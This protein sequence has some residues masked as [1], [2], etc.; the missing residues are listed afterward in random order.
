MRRTVIVF[1]AIFM[2]LGG[3]RR[4]RERDAAFP[5]APVILISID[6]LRSDHLPIYGYAGVAT[7]AID[8]FRQ[9]AILARAAWSHSP[10]TLPSHLSML[11]GVAPAEHGVR[12]NIGYRFRAAAHAYLP[13]LLRDRG[14]AT[15]A[16][17]SSYVLRS[18]SGIDACFDEYE[19]SI[20]PRP[21]A[22]FA[23]YQRPGSE[24]ARTA[25]AWITAQ[26]DRPFFHFFHIYEPHVPYDPP[27]PYRSRYPSAYDGEIA[28][29]DAIV[30]AFLDELRKSGVYDRALI[31]LTSDHGEGLGDHGEDQH[32][33]LLYR[34]AIAVPLLIKLP[35][36]A[37]RG[38]EI[39]RNVALKDLTPTVLRAL[40]I[41]LPT[42]MSGHSILE[43][44]PAETAPIFAET[45]YPR[46]HLGWSDLASLIRGNYHYIHG[47]KP[48][49][50]D[51]ARDPAERND[52]A[53]SERREV[54]R[55][56]D[57]I[58]PSLVP[59]Q[60]L[61]AI[62]P[63]AAKRL[64]ALGYVGGASVPGGALP[65]PRDR[66]PV[67]VEFRD[68][69]ALASE[70]RYDS[71]ID[72]LHALL[73]KDPAMT[74]V[75]LK[76]AETLSEA[77]RDREA[78]D[79][80]AEVIAR[81]PMLSGD[82]LLAA[83][84][85]HLR[86]GEFDRAAQLADQAALDT[87]LKAHELRARVFAAQKRFAAAETEARAA[88]DPTNPQPASMLV[89]AEVL[90]AKGDYQ[91]ALAAIDRA[92]ESAATTRSG[93]VYRLEF[94][95]GDT[96]AKLGR[97]EEARAAI[98]HEI[99]AFPSHLEAYGVRAVLRLVTGDPAGANGAMEEMVRANPNRAAAEFA[100]KTMQALDDPESAARWRA[101]AEKIP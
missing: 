26:G 8:R 3:C 53:A 18:E 89:L 95:R 76:L 54:A 94:L 9:D 67:L 69:L 2:M 1:A 85:V 33:I 79:A 29:A 81:M 16:A 28:H 20:D 49:L 47:P 32:S 83:G 43:T 97:F 72:A 51:L 24:T 61:E 6:T 7:P 68:A 58:A 75:R 13:C 70:R 91:G 5:N 84:Y 40:S 63:E 96:L 73:A 10:M 66:I 48:E 59:L 25:L 98:D 77:G 41:G 55:F 15:G 87:Q 82:V 14:Y 27:E 44:A 42:G 65:S 38:E 80:Y 35:G 22:G 74:E 99:A 19:D 62:D 4:E 39:A 101:R 23:E 78:S 31:I 57:E 11:T 71:A 45:M 12:N 56:R 86:L 52:L 46:I 100:A 93:S 50:Y 92:A 60:P 36:N 90:R 64:A 17:V 30:G 88:V 21:D 37:R 34:E